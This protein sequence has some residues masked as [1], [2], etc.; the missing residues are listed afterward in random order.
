MVVAADGKP[1][2]GRFVEGRRIDGTEDLPG[3]NPAQ[4]I[5]QRNH[6]RA[7]VGGSAPN[8]LKCLLEL[9]HVTPLSTAARRMP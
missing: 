3:Q 4:C 8:D 2:H 6:F 9:Y 5:F 1:V 7:E